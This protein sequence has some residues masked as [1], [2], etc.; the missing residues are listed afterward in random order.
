MLRSMTGFGASDLATAAGRY[1]VEARSLNHRFLEIM[2]RL[3]R[4]LAPLEDRIRAL[5]QGRV[6]RGRVE[7]AIMRENYGKRLRTVRIDL[8]LAKAFASALNELK[9]ALELPGSPDLAM[10]SALPDLIRIEEQKE[11]LEAAWTAIA[12]GLEVALSRLVAMREREG[13]RLASDLGQRV[14]RL[15]ERADEIERRA[16]LVVQ[17]HAA[18]LTRRIEE[19]IG[20]PPVDEGRL[21]AEVAIFADRSDIAE[22]T[23]RFRSHVA[24]MQQMLIGDG[25]AGRTLEFLV[26]E[27]G[28][29]ANTI[30]SKANDVEISRA[31]IAVKGDL[32]SLREQIQ[33]LE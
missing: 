18:R 23:T 27:L 13:A 31:V 26:Q 20:M 19:L 6:L 25:P 17:E 7:V 8:D 24:Q 30:G 32:E 28:R 16:P 2:V 9:Q 5:V 33:N 29:E 12:E 4:E 10:L 11:D 3:P 21:A 14:R 15:A 22:E 1:T